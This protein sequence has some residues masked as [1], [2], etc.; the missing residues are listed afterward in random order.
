[1]P[2]PERDQIETRLF[3]QVNDITRLWL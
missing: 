3:Q 2:F 1:M